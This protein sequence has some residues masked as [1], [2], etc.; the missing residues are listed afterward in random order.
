MKKLILVVL[1]IVLIAMAFRF[2]SDHMSFQNQQSENIVTNAKDL[3]DNT[4]YD[5][6]NFTCSGH[7]VLLNGHPFFA[8]G[9]GY[10]PTPVGEHPNDS[11]NGDYFTSNYAY[12]YKPDLDK[13]REMG[14]NS[15]RIYSWYPDKDHSDFLNYAYNG[16]TNPIYVAVGYYM[17]PGTIIG[18]FD[19]KLALFK[20]LA[21]KTAQ[22]PDIIGYQLGNENLGNDLNNPDYWNKLNQIAAALKAIAPNKLTFTGL[23]DDGMKSV[24]V[25]NQYMT[26]LDVWGINIF[27]GRHLGDLYSS[28]ASASTKPMFITEVGFPATIREGGIPKPMPDNGEMVGEY[29]KDVIE[30]IDDNSSADHSDDV[31]AGVYWFMWNDEWWKQECP[32]CWSPNNQP[33][34]CS[35]ST[36]DFT[37]T[38][39]TDNFPG[40][41]WDEEWFGLYT[42]DRQPRAAVDVLHSLWHH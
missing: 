26:S 8:K 13:M 25:G 3:T 42:V 29:C 31:V 34:S 12:I 2:N 19:E 36:H 32:A 20:T 6:T 28:Y 30:E 1:P 9:V 10:Q 27:R 15:L 39:Y 21:T 14:V 41:W 5:V 23:V 38:N 4:S 40:K 37:A 18:N 24:Q 35:K 11:P 33:C 17:P 7:Q 16:G 22:H